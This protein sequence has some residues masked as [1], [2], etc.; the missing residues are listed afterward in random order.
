MGLEQERDCKDRLMFSRR[1]LADRGV[2]RITPEV[3]HTFGKKCLTCKKYGTEVED[4]FCDHCYRL[5]KKRKE[6]IL[7]TIPTKRTTT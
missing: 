1:D 5:D 4:G 2:Y 7:R 3:L 6:S